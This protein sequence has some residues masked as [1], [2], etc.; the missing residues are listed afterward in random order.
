[1]EPFRGDLLAGDSNSVPKM[2]N[3]RFVVC[4][5]LLGEWA[6]LNHIKTYNAVD[7]LA[8]HQHKILFSPLHLFRE[9]IMTVLMRF[10][11]SYAF[12]HGLNA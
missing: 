3:E 4:I 11:A 5:R 1:M 12:C 6:I 2:A 10:K 9:F 7:L 8:S